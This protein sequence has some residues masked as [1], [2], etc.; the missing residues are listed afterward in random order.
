MYFMRLMKEEG[1]Y[2]HLSII[3]L[4]SFSYVLGSSNVVYFDTLRHLFHR[5]V[6]WLNNDDCCL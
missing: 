5:K 1:S 2:V 3:R 4:I 6:W